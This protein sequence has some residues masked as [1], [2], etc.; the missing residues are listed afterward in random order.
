MGGGESVKSY[1]HLK[2]MDPHPKGSGKPVSGKS[3]DGH[4]MVRFGCCLENGL[5]E[6]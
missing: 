1:R 6:I 4:N 3:G 5:E 2:A